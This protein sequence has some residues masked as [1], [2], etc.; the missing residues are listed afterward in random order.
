MDN[1]MEQNKRQ[2]Y[3]QAGLKKWFEEI[4][5]YKTKITS[6]DLLTWEWSAN[7]QS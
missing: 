7:F 6:N 2:S 5:E 4:F 1:N 3:G